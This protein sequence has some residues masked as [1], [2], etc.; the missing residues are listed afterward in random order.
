MNNFRACFRVNLKIANV[1]SISSSE[2]LVFI[3]H[4]PFATFGLYVHYSSTQRS[5]TCPSTGGFAEPNRRKKERTS[6]F[7]SAIVV[8]VV[9]L[10]SCPTLLRSSLKHCMKENLI[11]FH[12]ILRLDT[13]AHKRAVN[14]L[15]WSGK[16]CRF[17][18]MSEDEV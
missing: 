5:Q 16:I 12:F 9:V 1:C 8:A 6:L 3:S 11:K 13:V 10:V 18:K 15:K 2:T 7:S 4:S 14:S 17:S